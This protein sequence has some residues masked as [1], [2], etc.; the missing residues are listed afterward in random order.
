VPKVR[1]SELLG[2]HFCQTSLSNISRA[3]H[4]QLGTGP[5]NL[6]INAARG[7]VTMKSQHSFLKKVWTAEI[8]LQRRQFQFISEPT[9]RSAVPGFSPGRGY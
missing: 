3:M 1:K 7:R 4:F 9:A 2:L 5:D 6:N 8:L